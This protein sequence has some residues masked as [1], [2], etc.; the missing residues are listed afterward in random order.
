MVQFWANVAI[1]AAFKSYPAIGDIG[2]QVALIPLVFD[3]IKGEENRIFELIITGNRYGFIVVIVGVF[4]SVLAPIFWS[5]WIYQGT[6]NANFYYAINLALTLAQV[7]FIIDSIAVV[8]KEDYAVKKQVKRF[9]FS[10]LARRNLLKLMRN[11]R[12]ICKDN[13]TTKILRYYFVC[14]MCLTSF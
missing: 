1:I 5:M 6:G 9:Q 10:S 3:E 7:M 14:A 2:I 12:K 8:L 4:V 13:R 11:L